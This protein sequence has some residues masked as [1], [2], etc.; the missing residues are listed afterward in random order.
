MVQLLRDV[1]VGKGIFMIEL[2]SN[3][4]QGLATSASVRIS[5]QV[6]FASSL[7][8]LLKQVQ[9]SHASKAH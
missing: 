1:E 5:N 2:D 4:G 9:S 6:R 8:T 3:R 7:V